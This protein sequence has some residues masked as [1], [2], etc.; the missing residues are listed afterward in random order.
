MLES[1][2]AMSWYLCVPL[3]VHLALNLAL[4]CAFLAGSVYGE[5]QR[6][7]MQGQQCYHYLLTTYLIFENV[8]IV[9]GIIPESTGVTCCSVF[10]T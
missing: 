3:V 7:P 5:A 6:C 8:L 10:T 1:L 9:Y 2:C 4:S